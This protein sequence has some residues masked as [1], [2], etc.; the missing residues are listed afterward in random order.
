MIEKGTV[1]IRD[2][3][4]EAV[5]PSVTIAPDVWVVDGTGLTVYPGLIDALSTLGLPDMAPPAAP[6]PARGAGGR[7]A[8]AVAAT[9]GPNAPPPSRGPED[10]PATTSWA[11]AEDLI[12][13][14]DRRIG[15]FRNGGFTTAATFPNK[16]IFAGQGA[17]VDLAG[18]KPGQMV[19]AGPVGQ[20]VSM[21]TSGSFGNFPG[22]LMGTIAYIRQV[23]LD[24]GQYKAARSM[25]AKNA[26]G[27]ARPE[28]DRTLEGIIE[29]PRVLLPANR[30]VEMV[31]MIRFANELK[32]PFV[33]YGGN[34]AY[35]SADLLKQ[36]N[37]PVLVDLKWPEK[38]RDGDPD[39]VETHRTLELRAKA[40]SGPSELAKAGVRFAFYTGG[41]TTPKETMRAV[42]K[43]MDAG[44]KQEDALRAMTLSPAE[45]YGVADR[46]GSI[47]KGK[48]ANLVVT[49]GDL[50][51]DKTVV[52][53]VFVDG[54]KFEPV[55]EPAPT[56]PRTREGQ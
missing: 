25:Y 10:R 56:T 3:L 52:K 11:K 22:S 2:G 31:R 27:L 1:V 49:N 42:K 51:H 53:Y 44:L 12:Q 54:V 28:Y 16:G 29:S 40:P 55:E 15:T 19:V 9:L 36:A 43:A 45:I 5:G 8:A 48:I 4:I 41:L 24:A 26:R 46:L 17:I 30:T 47:E 18:E 39:E 37:A 38:S 6:A 20:Y 35:R 32:Q 34:E 7:T 14:S 13:T 23:Y 33:L 21:S 50:F